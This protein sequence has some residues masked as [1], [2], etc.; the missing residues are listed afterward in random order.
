MVELEYVGVRT[1]RG[2]SWN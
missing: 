1:D 2:K